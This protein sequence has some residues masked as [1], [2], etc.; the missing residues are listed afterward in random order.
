MAAASKKISLSFNTLSHA[1]GRPRP[2]RTDVLRAEGGP[3]RVQRC[4]GCGKPDLERPYVQQRDDCVGFKR[5]VDDA[6]VAAR[7]FR[8][9]QSASSAAMRTWPAW[10]LRSEK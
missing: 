10:F 2:P 8:A 9:E 5:W 7:A 4:Q 1:L 3:L 6:A